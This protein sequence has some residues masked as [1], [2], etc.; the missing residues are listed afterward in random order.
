MAMNTT[1][2]MTLGVSE[3]QTRFPELVERVAGGEEITITSRGAP[4]ARLVPFKSAKH[5][6]TVAERRAAI[7]GMIALRERLSLGGLK[8]RDLIDEGRP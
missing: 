6:P 3:A 1:D 8:I 2:A 5:E 7:E 4:L